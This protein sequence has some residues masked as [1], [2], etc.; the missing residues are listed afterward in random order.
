[1]TP[2]GA[3]PLPRTDVGRCHRRP[4][5]RPR[6]IGGGE[7]PTFLGERGQHRGPCRHPRLLVRR[8]QEGEAVSPDGQ[9]GRRRPRR[10]VD[11]DTRPV[12]TALRREWHPHQT[13]TVE[14]P[15]V[16]APSATA[17]NNAPRPGGDRRRRRRWRRRRASPRA[18]HDLSLTGTGSQLGA[19]LGPGQRPSDD[20]RQPLLGGPAGTGQRRRPHRTRPRRRRPATRRSTAWP[21]AAARRGPRTRPPRRSG[22]RANRR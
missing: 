5:S 2:S 15:V 20:E 19:P 18:N 16:A 22:R 21:A 4:G 10:A 17:G 13:D 3:P 8:R 1:M 11:D 6:S 12:V 14:D 7:Q 9:S